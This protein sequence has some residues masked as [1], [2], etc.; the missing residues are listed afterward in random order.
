M[1]TFHPNI[2]P[3]LY[4]DQLP[5]RSQYQEIAISRFP[6]ISTILEFGETSES[7]LFKPQSSLLSESLLQTSFISHLEERSEYG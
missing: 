2:K 7:S 3:A 1:P 5:A 6:T 4:L